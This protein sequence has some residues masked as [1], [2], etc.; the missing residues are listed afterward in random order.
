MKQKAITHIRFMLPR[1][2]RKSFYQCMPL[3]IVKDFYGTLFL[4]SE[5]EAKAVF[6]YELKSNSL[7]MRQIKK[8]IK[9]YFEA[10]DGYE[11]EIVRVTKTTI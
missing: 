10:Y 11:C 9:R 8:H 4:V 5:G 6:V 7:N 3:G 1:P 2:A